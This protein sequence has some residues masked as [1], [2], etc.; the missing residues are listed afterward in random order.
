MEAFGWIQTSLSIIVALSVTRLMVSA[1]HMF[2]AR[3]QVKSDWIPYAWALCIFF[4]ALQFSWTFLSL[5]KTSTS[6]TFGVFLSLL[7][8]VLPLFFA[9][10]LILPNTESQAGTDLEVWF[11]KNGRMSLLC[12]AFYSLAVYPFNRY[13]FDLSP[14]DRPHAGIAAVL[15]LVGF[16]TKSRRVLSIVTILELILVVY[17]AVRMLLRS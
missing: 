9:S 17:F 7:L 8:M 2:I 12:F 4:L 1:S 15:A 3:K 5:G 13:F 6:W 11:Q 10:A 14:L 16:F